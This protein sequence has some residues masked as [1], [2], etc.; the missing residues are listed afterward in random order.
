LLQ[1]HKYSAEIVNAVICH[2]GEIFLHAKQ[3]NQQSVCHEVTETVKVDNLDN[4]SSEQA[5]VEQLQPKKWK[6][7]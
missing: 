4:I 3:D 6:K 2:G 7:A 1:L 5:I